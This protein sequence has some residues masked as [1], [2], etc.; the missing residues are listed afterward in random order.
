MK[1]NGNISRRQFVSMSA[2]AGLGL[3]LA[4]CGSTGGSSSKSDS[5]SGSSASGKVYYLNFKPEVDS[6][7]QELAKAYTKKTGVEVSVVT[8]AS[9]T[10]EQKLQSEM[11]KSSAPT[12][13][14]VNGPIGLK[15]W[16]DY[17]ADLTGT[18]ILNELTNDTSRSRMATRSWASTTSRRTTASSTTRTC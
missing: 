7:W 16:K 2:V 5:G 4:G 1:A 6:Q 18:D 13:F 12:L 8:A 3:A 15:S 17:C 14:Q 9:D 11:S 10:Y